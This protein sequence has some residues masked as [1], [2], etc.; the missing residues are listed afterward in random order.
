[1]HSFFETLCIFSSH[2]HA[3]VHKNNVKQNGVNVYSVNILDTV[4]VW[5]HKNT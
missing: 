2:Q 1:M 3:S 5:N 4:F